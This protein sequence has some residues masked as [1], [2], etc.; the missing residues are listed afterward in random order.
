MQFTVDH[1]RLALETNLQVSLGDIDS[2]LFGCGA[3]WD[4]NIDGNF[5]QSL[6]PRVLICR[7]AIS[8]VG[9]GTLSLFLFVLLALGL[10]F[11]RSIGLS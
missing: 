6:L 11:S 2:Q 9:D 7:P 8:R 4:D 10:L 3:L 5:L 1:E